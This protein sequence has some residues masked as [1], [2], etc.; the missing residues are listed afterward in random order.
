MHGEILKFILLREV[1]GCRGCESEEGES[2]LNRGV[3]E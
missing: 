1:R 2:A 3:Y